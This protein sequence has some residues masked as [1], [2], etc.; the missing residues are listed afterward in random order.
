MREKV[1][2]NKEQDGVVCK[3]TTSVLEKVDITESNK[4]CNIVFDRVINGADLPCQGNCALR[5][6]PTKITQVPQESQHVN[7]CLRRSNSQQMSRGDLNKNLQETV[8]SLFF[9]LYIPSHSTS[10]KRREA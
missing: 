4:A 1:G 3:P 2:Q 8:F 6:S 7:A 5:K 10:W 9:N